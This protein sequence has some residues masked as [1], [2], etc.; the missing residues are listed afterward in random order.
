MRKL[1]TI[2]ARWV[3]SVLV[4]ALMTMPLMLN[5][6]NSSGTR[7]NG[8]GSGSGFSTS[9]NDAPVNENIGYLVGAAFIL[10]IVSIYYRQLKKAVPSVG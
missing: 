10:G 7:G 4:I 1:F 9:L 8:S 5:A 3:T 6:Q 2:P